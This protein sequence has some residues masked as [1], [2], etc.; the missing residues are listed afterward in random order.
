MLFDFGLTEKSVRD[1]YYHPE[2]ADCMVDAHDHDGC[3]Y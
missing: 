2:T 3:G 1:G